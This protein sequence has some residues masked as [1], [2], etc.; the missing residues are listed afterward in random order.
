MK[1]TANHTANVTAKQQ[2]K[3]NNIYNR[4]NI[5]NIEK[6]LKYS[7]QVFFKTNASTKVSHIVFKKYRMI[8][9]KPL[10]IQDYRT[11]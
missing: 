8:K 11:T 6:K 9:K 5:E 1:T 3:Y 4:D 7:F 2:T 10:K